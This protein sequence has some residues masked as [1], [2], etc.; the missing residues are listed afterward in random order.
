MTDSGELHIIITNKSI[1]LSIQVARVVLLGRGLDEVVQDINMNLE[2]EKD[3]Q[4]EQ[5]IQN[6]YKKDSEI[7]KLYLNEKP[8]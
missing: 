4:Q 7:Q 8:K 2:K 5:F 6:I 1:F 3:I